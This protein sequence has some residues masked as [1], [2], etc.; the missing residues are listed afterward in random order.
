MLSNTE[1]CLNKW[2]KKITTQIK[3]NIEGKHGYNYKAY[4]TGYLDRSVKYSIVGGEWLGFDWVDYGD[5]TAYGTYNI[6][7]RHWEDPIKELESEEFE[8]EFTD[9]LI[10]DGFDS[11]KK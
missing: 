8:K 6:K 10:K 9:A 3:G 4:K 1:E 11:I 5:Y 7:A 2:G